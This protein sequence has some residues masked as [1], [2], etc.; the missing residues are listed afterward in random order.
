MEISSEDEDNLM[1]SEEEQAFYDQAALGHD[2]EYSDCSYNEK[3]QCGSITCL[4]KKRFD[5]RRNMQGY[6]NFGNF[7]RH[8]AKCASNIKK[9]AVSGNDEIPMEG[10]TVSVVDMLYK[11]LSPRKHVFP[12]L[13]SSLLCC[14]L[15]TCQ[16][17]VGITL[18][19]FS[20]S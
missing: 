12:H 20:N 10:T 18:F 11:Y 3:E 6:L 13:F 16:S 1:I 2:G 8:F 15:S 9:I 7:N 17:I 5:V 14:F 19:D 4:C